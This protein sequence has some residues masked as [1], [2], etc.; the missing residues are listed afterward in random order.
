MGSLSVIT[1]DR[2]QGSCRTVHNNCYKPVCVHSDIW[3]EICAYTRKHMYTDTSIYKLTNTHRSCTHSHLSTAAE[4]RGS[5]NSVNGPLNYQRS[6]HRH[7]LRWALEKCFICESVL[8]FPAHSAPCLPLQVK[9]SRLCEQDKILKDLE[10]R[11]SSL[12]EDKVHALLIMSHNTVSFYHSERQQAQCYVKY[13][14]WWCHIQRQRCYH[15]A[16]VEFNNSVIQ[17]SQSR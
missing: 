10:A 6:T 15:W 4:T 2:D 16:T 13:M 7:T 3:K 14:T 8:L 17:L 1:P 9:L 11:I 5:C 12:K